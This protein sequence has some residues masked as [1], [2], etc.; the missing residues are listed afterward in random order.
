VGMESG[1][2][3]LL[4][5][6]VDKVLASHLGIEAN[7]PKV[8]SVRKCKLTCKAG[9]AFPV[10]GL[11]LGATPAGQNGFSQ[12][13]FQSNTNQTNNQSHGQTNNQSHGQ[14]TRTRAPSP[15]SAAP[16]APCTL[17][18][19]GSVRGPSAPPQ[20]DPTLPSPRHNTAHPP[21][22]IQRRTP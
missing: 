8:V 4:V 10:L 18:R 20:A 3:T 2:L 22:E 6:I 19:R 5:G 14:A 16:S 21:G 13:T 7:L 1:V 15:A 17:S 12:A 11:Q 9:M